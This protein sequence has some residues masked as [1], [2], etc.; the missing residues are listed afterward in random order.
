V[1][2][3]KPVMIERGSFR[4]VTNVTLRM[5]D[6]AVAQLPVSEE[7]EERV[8]IMEMTLNNLMGGSDIG[9]RDFLAR[10]DILGALGKT[11]MISNYTRFDRVTSYLRRYTKNWIG[12]AIGIPTLLEV[13][14][15]KYYADLEGG[16]LE[17]IGR[18][19]QGKVRLFVYP[20]KLT[21]NG[22]VTTA[23]RLEVKPELKHLYSYLLDNGYIVNIRDFEPEGLHVTPAAVL[24]AIRS[25]SPSWRKLVPQAAASVIQSEGLFGYR[26]AP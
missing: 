12:M 6:S 17:G 13:F 25:G 2:F 7:A 15:E 20:T 18:L 1:L 16:I 9:H 10:A 8:A 4:P 22:E 19:F 5:I 14:E 21:D 11:V 26:P 24:A 3:N 23:D